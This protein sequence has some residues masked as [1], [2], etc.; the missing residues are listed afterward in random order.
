[1]KTFKEY[2]IEM[3][4]PNVRHQSTIW[5]HGCPNEK[6]A[7]LIIKNGLQPPKISNRNQWQKRKIDNDKVYITED[8][9][10]AVWY[11]F[12]KKSGGDNGYVFVIDGLQL[13]DVRPD[14]DGVSS[15]LFDVWHKY[16]G[17]ENAASIFGMTP[18]DYE[19][20]ETMYVSFLDVIK[21]FGIITKYK[22]N[23]TGV[24]HEWFDVE[25]S[26]VKIINNLSDSQILDLIDIGCNIAHVGSLFPK[27]TWMA[28]KRDFDVAKRYDG[29]FVNIKH[30]TEE[31][32]RKILKNDIGDD[33]RAASGFFDYATKIV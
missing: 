9:Q 26:V 20:P 18:K 31:E 10:E 27:E 8:L 29:N 3:A 1:M 19:I 30:M 32:K 2:L 7:L 14:V 22:H 33:K 11:A 21:K 23:E 5:Y 6:D 15:V 4:A 24:E 12:L 28:S 16:I 13:K 25:K 17:D